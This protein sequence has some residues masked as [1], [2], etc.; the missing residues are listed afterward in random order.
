MNVPFFHVVKFEGWKLH[1]DN[2]LF[3]E[4]QAC[5]INGHIVYFAWN[6]SGLYCPGVIITSTSHASQQCPGFKDKL[7]GYSNYNKK[8]TGEDFLC[9]FPE[10]INS[11]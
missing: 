2:A 8:N 7:Y 1:T 9:L 10:I 4:Q 6:N 3:I 5:T 11:S